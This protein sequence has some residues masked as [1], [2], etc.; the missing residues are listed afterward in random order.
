MK[1][2]QTYKT[3]AIT[4]IFLC[5]WLISGNL[6]KEREDPKTKSALD[7][8]SSVS[9]INS[10]ATLKSK[11]IK[12]SGFTEADK[13]VPV[14]AEVG[15][16]V[17]SRPVNQGDF[18]KEGDLL[19][20]LYIAG[21]EAFPK[22]TAP[23]SGYLESMTVDKGD[24]LNTGAPCATLIDPNPMFLIADI[25]E[26]DISKVRAGA[27][28][29]ARLISGREI[30]GKVSFVGTSADQS[31]RT[32]R[33]EISVDNKDRS[34]RDG[35]SALISIESKEVPAHKISPAIFS[36]DEKGILGVRIVDQNN[37]V[38]FKP[39]EILQ[40]TIDGVWVTGLPDTS[41]IITRGQEFVFEGQTV[42]VFEVDQPEA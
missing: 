9:V 31:T 18:V 22:V 7:T 39:I 32:F 8:L 11:L 1:I 36:L 15:G 12:A 38:E 3:S 29:T 35:V 26:K 34:I 37:L 25:A 42:N 6:I 41:R 19:C 16:R 2:K 5:I 13:L 40:D 24:F 10:Q 14:R 27:E 20:Q 23:F 28:A 33:V 21:R 17:I 4:F 30:N